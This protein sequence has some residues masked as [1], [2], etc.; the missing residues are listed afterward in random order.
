MGENVRW[1]KNY[2]KED[3]WFGQTPAGLRSTRIKLV[4]HVQLCPAECGTA[5]LCLIEEEQMV[6]VSWQHQPSLPPTLKWICGASQDKKKMGEWRKGTEAEEQGGREGN[7]VGGSSAAVSQ[8][9][10]VA[11]LAKNCRC[12]SVKEDLGFG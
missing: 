10:P 8:Y 2:I 1:H 3:Q 12:A 5:L 4:L 11:A 7:W 9:G 6:F